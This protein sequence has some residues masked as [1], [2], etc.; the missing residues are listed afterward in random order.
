[1][2]VEGQLVGALPSPV[3]LKHFGLPVLSVGQRYAIGAV[4]SKRHHEAWELRFAAE[5][6]QADV[7]TALSAFRRRRDRIQS[8]Q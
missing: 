5:A 3:T 4:D 6:D 1:V 8:K 7:G 2:E